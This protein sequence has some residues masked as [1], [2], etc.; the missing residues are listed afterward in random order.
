MAIV[1]IHCPECDAVLR[2]TNPQ[3]GKKGKC[4]KCAALITIP[5]EAEEA[6]S[7]QP[8]P[9]PAAPRPRVVAQVADDEEDE[10]EAEVEPE[11]RPRRMVAAAADGDDEQAEEE[12]PRRK[13]LKKK[14]RSA[15]SASSGKGLLIGLIV[16]GVLLVFSGGGGLAFWL[17]SSGQNRGTG[18]E[19]PL[20]YV[21]ADTTVA[22][23]LDFAALAGQPEIKTPAQN[24]LKGM[25]GELLNGC[26]KETKLSVDD[27]VQQVVV[28]NHTPLDQANRPGTGLMT[29]VIKSRVPFNPRKVVE[30]FVSAEKKKQNG[31]VF[32][33]VRADP[34]QRN[35][36]MAAFAGVDLP[37]LFMPSDRIIVATNVDERQLDWMFGSDGTALAL[38]GPSGELLRKAGQ[39]HAWVLLPLD[40]KIKEQMRQGM[41][42]L[43]P[44]NRALLE[45]GKAAALW[46]NLEGQQVKIGA[47]LACT[48]A[49]A[50]KQITDTM[51]REWAKQKDQAA[52][53]GAALEMFMP[54][55]GNLVK[56]VADSTRISNEGAV[57]QFSAQVSMK[58]LTAVINAV[59]QRAAQPPQGGRPPG[60]PVF[61]DG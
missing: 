42:M 53:Q 29:V 17:L 5:D 61:P 6:E 11:V 2:L 15:R 10:V 3:P 54:G 18:K 19:D 27:L 22:F 21:A 24:V 32:Y 9:R 13:K 14:R 37:T 8:K 1:T 25:C 50:A 23:G 39:G 4:P 28:A 55:V 47:G 58:S 59:Q 30:G 33:R 51:Q 41:A 44:E 34:S 12:R 57:A 48:D 60:M 45:Q 35:P 52:G 46:G 20:A 38:A 49:N 43:P 26:T 31:K 7:I 16:A 40:G 36:G 56:E